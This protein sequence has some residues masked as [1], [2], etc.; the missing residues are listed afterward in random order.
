[1]QE[2]QVWIPQSV[3][4]QRRHKDLMRKGSLHSRFEV[5]IQT[6]L[7]DVTSTTRTDRCAN[8]VGVFMHGEKY[9][10]TCVALL[11]KLIGNLDTTAASKGN[12][13]DYEVGF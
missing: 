2:H 7:D 3:L 1:M 6:R 8:K 10:F 5:A 13:Q 11:P 9:D 4:L 12:V